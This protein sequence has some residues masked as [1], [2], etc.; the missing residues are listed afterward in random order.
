MRRQRMPVWFVAIPA[1]FM[2]VLP[3]WAMAYQIFGQAVGSTQSWIEQERW[4]LVGIGTISLI[5]EAWM[6]V[7]GAVA[8]KKLGKTSQDQG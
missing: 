2:L 4:L 3:A 5:L 8:W 7:E 6:V 1:F